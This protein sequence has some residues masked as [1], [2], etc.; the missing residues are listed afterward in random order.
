MQHGP[1]WGATWKRPWDV[2]EFSILSKLTFSRILSIGDWPFGPSIPPLS[3]FHYVLLSPASFP[4]CISLSFPSVSVVLPSETKEVSQPMGFYI[5]V[6]INHVYFL[7]VQFFYSIYFY[8]Y[9]YG[10][11]MNIKWKFIMKNSFED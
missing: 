10:S 1:G 9:C 6:F 8:F 7:Y 2:W 5:L 11:L 3:L 4:P